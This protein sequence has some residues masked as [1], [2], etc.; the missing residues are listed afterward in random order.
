MFLIA[1]L[2]RLIMDKV[3]SIKQLSKN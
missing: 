1:R 2:I 3:I